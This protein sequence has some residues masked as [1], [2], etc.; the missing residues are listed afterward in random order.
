MTPQPFASSIFWN[1]YKILAKF[2]SMLIPLFKNIGYR[3]GNT[4]RVALL[5]QEEATS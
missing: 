5:V 3:Y 4:T 2:L 1:I